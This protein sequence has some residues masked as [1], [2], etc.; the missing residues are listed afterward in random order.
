MIEPGVDGGTA[1]AGAPVAEPMYPRKLWYNTHW[2]AKSALL[3]VAVI[4]RY[5]V[6]ETIGMRVTNV[7]CSINIICTLSR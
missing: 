6:A 1:V 2:W 7:P 3:A 5:V 4:D